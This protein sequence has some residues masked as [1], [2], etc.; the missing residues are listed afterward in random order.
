MSG[1][2]T[3]NPSWL[4]SIRNTDKPVYLHKDGHMSSGKSFKGLLVSVAESL[5]VF[6]EYTS[7]YRAN[8]AMQNRDAYNAVWSH[9]RSKYGLGATTDSKQAMQD[10]GF[11]PIQRYL[12]KLEGRNPADPHR[13]VTGRELRDIMDTARGLYEAHGS[14]EYMWITEDADEPYDRILRGVKLPGRLKAREQYQGKVPGVDNVNDLPEGMWDPYMWVPGL[15]SPEEIAA[16]KAEKAAQEAAAK[17]ALQD[18]MKKEGKLPDEL[19]RATLEGNRAAIKPMV[20]SKEGLRELA[21]KLGYTDPETV[22][23]RRDYIESKL[24][25]LLDETPKAKTEKLSDDEV[26]ELIKTAID[27]ALE[28]SAAGA[29]VKGGLRAAARKV[30]HALDDDNADRVDILKLTKERVHTAVKDPERMDRL[31]KGRLGVHNRKLD[32]ARKAFVE[33]Y[34]LKRALAKAKDDGF[35]VSPATVDDMITEG[36]VKSFEM[37]KAKA[38]MQSFFGKAG[39]KMS[40]SFTQMSRTAESVREKALDDEIVQMEFKEQDETTARRLSTVSE[41]TEMSDLD[42]V[43]DTEETAGAGSRIVV[44][45]EVHEQPE[46]TTDEPPVPPQAA[47]AQPA[48]DEPEI[49]SQA[50]TPGAERRTSVQSEHIAPQDL[51]MHRLAER[52]RNREVPKAQPYKGVDYFNAGLKSNEGVEEMP[53]SLRN[54][55]AAKQVVADPAFLRTALPV[56][57]KVSD[58]SD[59]QVDY[60]RTTLLKHVTE[61]TQASPHKLITPE[62][63]R[64]MLQ[65]ICQ[66]A[67]DSTNDAKLRVKTLSKKIFKTLGRKDAGLSREIKHLERTGRRRVDRLFSNKSYVQDCVDKGMRGYKVGEGVAEAVK[68]DVKTLVEAHVQSSR[69]PVTDQDIENFVRIAVH[70][71]AQS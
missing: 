5:G 41:D 45:A 28:Q 70:Q 29:K 13:A 7:T 23:A 61:R 6:K 4:T 50:P 69:T 2:N 37:S 46:T 56:G 24:N 48:A 16:E 59:A 30:K 63:F 68:G 43:A 25:R 47:T 67:V 52:T 44:E 22:A 60:I 58:L 11:E 10:R 55:Q 33:Q 42:S 71:Y 64:T 3:Q 15:K 38:R 26:T 14:K 57:V 17:K 9:V 19:G 32:S 18:T 66:K 65:P 20:H 54:H 53:R 1:I 31:F 40:I 35:E 51:Y 49:V 21:G 36:M 62:E 34:A 8:K 39:Q 27:K 12:P